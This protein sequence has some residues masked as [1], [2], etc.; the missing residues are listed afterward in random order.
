MALTALAGPLTNMSLA[1][2]AAQIYKLIPNDPLISPIL[3]AVVLYNLMLAILNLIPIPPLDGSRVVAAILG[4]RLARSYL[5]IEQYGI[6]ILLIL[7]Y[8]PIG[9][10]SL[11]DILNNL[12][13]Y[14]IHL[15][16]I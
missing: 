14:S 2:V 4:Y 7:L 12:V 8:F 1:V 11:G 3:F 9:S 13:I 6:F 16:G 15:L 5:S 10:F